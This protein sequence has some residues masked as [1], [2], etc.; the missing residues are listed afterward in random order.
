M[1]VASIRILVLTAAAASAALPAGAD[2]MGGPGM[3]GGRGGIGAGGGFVGSSGPSFGVGDAV[4]AVVA[5]GVIAGAINDAVER[6]D[7]AGRNGPAEAR[8]V[9]RVI[10][11]E[12]YARR[13]N[14]AYLKL[15]SRPKNNGLSD[16]HLQ[17]VVIR[18]M[19]DKYRIAK[20]ERYDNDAAF[21]RSRA[22]NR[23]MI[24]INSR[25][26]PDRPETG[27]DNPHKLKKSGMSQQEHDLL[28]KPG[29]PAKGTE[30]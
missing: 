12:E 26:R 19:N 14:D 27:A 13:M 4:G 21:E 7:A 3:G 16:A 1:S 10:S 15:R 2:P 23:E 5:A 30:W 9:P 17:D 28:Y 25:G 20:P 29:T 11:E 6:R 8:P 24:R 18:A 22:Q